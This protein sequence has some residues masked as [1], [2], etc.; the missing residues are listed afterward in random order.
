MD[1]KRIIEQDY[2]RIAPRFEEWSSRAEEVRPW[3]LDETK[4]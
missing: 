2:D 4:P 3:F 1:P